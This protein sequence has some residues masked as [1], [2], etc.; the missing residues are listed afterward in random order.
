MLNLKIGSNLEALDASEP[1]DVCII[2]SGFS[3][4]ILGTLLAENNIKTLIVESG[5][6]LLNWLTNSRLKQLAKYE[7]SGNTN[8]LLNRTTSRIIGGNSNFW[9]GRCD[10]FQ[11]SD[12]ED[13]PYL[14]KDNP[15][16]IKYDDIEPYYC[17]A[18]QILRVRGGKQSNFMPP[19]SEPLPLPA[20]T[21]I[22][23]LRRIMSETSVIID[24]SPTA[25]PEKAIRFFRVNNEILPR[26]VKSPCGTLV[27]GAT[28]T[29]IV[30]NGNGSVDHIEIKT[31]DGISKKAVARQ[32]VVACG[33]IQTPRLLLLSKSERY[34]KGIGN[35]SDR[36]GKGFNE[37]PGLTI[38]GKIKHSMDTIIPRHKIGRTRHLYEMFR[39]DG[40]GAIHLAFIQSWFF[41]HHL[42]HYTARDIIPHLM[43]ITNRLKRPTLLMGATIEQKP[44]NSNGV[45]L[46]K[47]EM[48]IFGNPIAHLTLN[49]SEEDLM[50]LDNLRKLLRNLFYMVEA[51]DLEEI[52]VTWSR[53]HI[54]TCRM[55]GNPATSVVDKNLKVHDCRNLYLCGSEVFV[56]GSGVAPVL[57]ISAFSCRLAERLTRLF[58]NH[59]F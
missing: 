7:L 44:V 42:R 32:F 28:A 11:P 50:L 48:D 40:L 41:P 5:N 15:W 31:L 6:S 43:K 21:D 12:F 34:P 9:T 46:S 37:H 23:G 45:A 55:G 14:P 49:Y 22:S 47:N 4:T 24:T 27:S 29:K 20:G 35:N 18:E 57:T 54:G 51:D 36:V 58:K 1:F 53:H 38:Y 16:P 56:S 33:G 59:D 3:G 39:K 8:Y 25:T 19:R 17:K 52:E 26:F 2:G 13:H 10:R 30:P